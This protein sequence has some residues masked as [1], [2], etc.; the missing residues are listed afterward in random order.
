MSMMKVV[1]T[2]NVEVLQ[3]MNIS[4]AD[5]ISTDQLDTSLVSVSATT[6][7]QTGNVFI[8]SPHRVGT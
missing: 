1:E 7:P 4:T 8:V 2:D 3:L 5:N 6:V